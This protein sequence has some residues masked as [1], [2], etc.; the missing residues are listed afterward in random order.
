MGAT[1]SVQRNTGTVIHKKM[2]SHAMSGANDVSISEFPQ[3]FK[4]TKNDP[5]V[6]RF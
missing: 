4:V 2:P 3:K 1:A 5:I 6:R